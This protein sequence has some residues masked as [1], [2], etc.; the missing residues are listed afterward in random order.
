MKIVARILLAAVAY[1]VGVVLSGAITAALRLPQP[2]LPPGTVEAQ[3]FRNLALATLLLAAGLLLLAR[4]L[5]GA[6]GK[7]LLAMAALVFV[8][9]GL[10]TVIEARVFSNI[11]GKAGPTMTLQNV[12]PAILLAAVLTWPA[13]EPNV[14]PAAVVRWTPAAWVGRLLAAWLAFP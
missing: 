14:A 2:A 9:V 11:I 3:L 8:C 1:L 12:L 5:R 6:W 7:R 4:G 13:R 10:N